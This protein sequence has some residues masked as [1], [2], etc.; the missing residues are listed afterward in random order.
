MRAG[1]D[2]ARPAPLLA[3]AEQWLGAW[4]LTASLG[5]ASAATLVQLSDP[6]R[7]RKEWSSNLTGLVDRTLR[8][9]EFLRLMACNLRVMADVARFTSAL[10][11]R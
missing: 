2:S 8:S 10:R 11:S 1:D 7:L 3:M 4:R 5:W 9:P 6:Q